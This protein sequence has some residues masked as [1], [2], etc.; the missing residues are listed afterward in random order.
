MA[1]TMPAVLHPHRFPS[2]GHYVV[3]RDNLLFDGKHYR[4]GESLD[5]ECSIRARPRSLESQVR[6]RNLVLSPS[7]YQASSEAPAPKK[8][9]AKESRPVEAKAPAVPANI[10]S[11]PLRDLQTALKE[12]G[13]DHV[14]NKG[15]LRKRL[16]AALAG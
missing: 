1:T 10:M 7:D 15:Q 4:R 5:K 12:R 8:R 16:A 3:V 11:L 6:Y 13:L 14:G 2:D 9:E